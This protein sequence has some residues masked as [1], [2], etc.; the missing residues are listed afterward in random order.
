MQTVTLGSR[1]QMV[2][3]LA[4]RK[5]IPGMKPGAELA[6]SQLNDKA[7]VVQVLDE[8]WVEKSFGAMKEAWKGRDMIAE[9]KKMRDEWDEK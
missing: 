1:N 2:I 7:I 8:S 3:P 6:V 4:L 9:L 5:L